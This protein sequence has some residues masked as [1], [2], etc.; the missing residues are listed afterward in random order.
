MLD[1]ERLLNQS[2]PQ[3]AAKLWK[4]DRVHFTVAGSNLLGRLFYHA[5]LN[6]SYDL[7]QMVIIIAA[8]IA[9]TSGPPTIAMFY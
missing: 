2:D 7:W 1:L 5:M 8:M 3:Q 9:M 6:F 4:L